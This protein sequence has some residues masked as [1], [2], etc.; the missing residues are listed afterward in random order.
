VGL[1][2]GL[3]IFTEL[4]AFEQDVAQ[5]PGDPGDHPPE[6]GGARHLDGLGVQRGQDLRG[7]G[8]GQPGR[9]GGQNLADTVAE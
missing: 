4:G 9:T 1:Q 3:E 7:E 8:L 2:A 5:L 6:L